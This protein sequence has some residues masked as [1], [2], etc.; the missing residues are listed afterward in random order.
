[1]PEGKAYGF[2]RPVLKKNNYKSNTPFLCQNLPDKEKQKCIKEVNSKLLSAKNVSDSIDLSDPNNLKMSFTKKLL[3]G[4]ISSALLDYSNIG[5]YYWSKNNFYEAKHYIDNFDLLIP[6][7][8]LTKDNFF[9]KGSGRLLYGKTGLKWTLA[10]Q[11]IRFIEN[12]LRTKHRYLCKNNSSNCLEKAWMITQKIQSNNF[13]DQ[14]IKTSINNNNAKNQYSKRMNLKAQKSLLMLAANEKI[15]S[16]AKDWAYQLLQQI[17]SLS[18]EI[19]KEA[20]AIKKL[21]N[22]STISLSETQKLLTEDEIIIS[23][24]FSIE[25]RRPIVWCIGKN[26]AIEFRIIGFKTNECTT[27]KVKENIKYIRNA[28]IVNN[29]YEEAKNSLIF[30]RKM[31]IDS[32]K[33]PKSGSKLILIVDELLSGLPF[34]ILPLKSGKYLCEEYMVSY[35]PS[36]PIFAILRQNKSSNKNRVKYIGIAKNKHFNGAKQLNVNKFVGLLS[37][38]YNGIS[39]C[40][41]LEEIIY[42]KKNEI[43]QSKYVHFITH[44]LKTNGIHALSY[45]SSL[46]EDGLLTGE[47]ISTRL[48]FSADTVLITSCDS[49]GTAVIPD[50]GEAFSSLPVG[51]LSA[52]AKKIILTRWRIQE[53]VAQIFSQ[54]YLNYRE[55]YGLNADESFKKTREI[56]KNKFQGPSAY[57][58]W[59]LISD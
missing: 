30:L 35:I 37:K 23:Y 40:E 1:M 36:I 50:P 20:P 27:K 57:A 56:I 52:G 25:C 31:L 26:N 22:Y 53:R 47:E 14:L 42:A 12:I 34:E 8:Y 21:E 6:A 2:D 24:V 11:Y 48:K 55:K 46:L 9:I 18:D 16:N 45:G 33:L 38:Q 19:Y 4:K 15:L 29:N 5:M 10:H 41:A 13:L 39:I 51:V 7:S 58:A 28:I 43:E 44:S 54:Y 17:D 32:I 3:S 59:M 49:A